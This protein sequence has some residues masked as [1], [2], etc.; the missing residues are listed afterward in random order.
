MYWFPVRLPFETLERRAIV[1]TSASRWTAQLRRLRHVNVIMITSTCNYVSADNTAQF[2][3]STVDD[4]DSP[5]GQCASLVLK[6]GTKR[7]CEVCVRSASISANSRTWNR[8]TATPKHYRFIWSR[9]A[10]YKFAYRL[11]VRLTLPTHRAIRK[12]LANRR[13]SLEKCRLGFVAKPCNSLQPR[14][15]FRTASRVS[16][17]PRLR[18]RHRS[19][20][21]NKRHWRSRNVEE[22]D[23]LT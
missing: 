12:M 16:S 1:Q 11:F 9:Q 6:H 5:T 19:V 22:R 15:L 3:T 23:A 4:G 14:L 18:S 8:R 13:G 17:K 7:L 20:R 21:A 10:W 2:N